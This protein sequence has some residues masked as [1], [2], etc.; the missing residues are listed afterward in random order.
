MKSGMSYEILLKIDGNS[1]GAL[2]NY[3]LSI[4]LKCLSKMTGKK[5]KLQ[6]FFD[7]IKVIILKVRLDVTVNILKVL[8]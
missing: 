6:F 3:I 4:I 8:N 7:N 5:V 1:I 2:F